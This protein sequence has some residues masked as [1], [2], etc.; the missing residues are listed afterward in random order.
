M[1]QIEV[2]DHDAFPDALRW[3]AIAFLRVEWPF[4]FGGAARL[5]THPYPLSM[6]QIHIAATEGDVLL[7]YATLVQFDQ[8]QDGTRYRTLGLGNVFTFPPYRREGLGRQVI[9]TATRVLERSDAD[10]GALLCERRF[11]PMYAAAGWI[12]A[13]APT[14]EGT[15]DD[16][17]RLEAVRMLVFV[18]AAAQRAR[19][20]LLGHPLYVAEQW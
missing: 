11:I 18:S 2:F 5:Q 4:I 7:S 20:A 12:A 15:P 6:P 19:A 16:A 3:Q 9:D 13:D 14:F 10:I 1:P 8:A 17:K